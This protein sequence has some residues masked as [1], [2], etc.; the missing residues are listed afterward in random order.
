MSGNQNG[1]WGRM[2]LLTAAV[3]AWTIYDLSTAT[4]AP[5]Q[6]VL[7]MHYVALTLALIGLAGSLFKLATQK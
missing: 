3:A 4:E 7:I 6:A 5:R 1:K 2:A